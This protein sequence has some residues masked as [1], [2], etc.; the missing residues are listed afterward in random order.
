MAADTVETPAIRVGATEFELARI[1]ELVPA[2][3]LSSGC[4][5]FEDE[6]GGFVVVPIARPAMRI[7]RGLAADI[8]FEDP[9]V[10]RRHALLARDGDQLRVLDDRSLNGLFVNGVRVRSRVLADGDVIN[11]G[12]HRLHYAQRPQPEPRQAAGALAL[13][14]A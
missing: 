12:R 1:A 6:F 2:S 11:V 10:S 3:S 5:C 9:T 13:Q 14:A 4:L 7:G 8:S